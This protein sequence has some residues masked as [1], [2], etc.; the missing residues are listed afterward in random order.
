MKDIMEKVLSRTD[1]SIPPSLENKEVA[2]AFFG[3]GMEEFSELT[4]DKDLVKL[5]S[6][7]LALQA[8]KIILDLKQ[9]DWTKSVDIPKKMIF[10]I[11]DY[12]IDHIRDKYDLKLSFQEID[13]ISE[14]IVEIAKIRY[15]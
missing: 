6:E 8:D 7:E 5:I 10:L 9:V 1:S 15:R 13:K 4:K 11:G 3:V 2:K 14:R 12:I